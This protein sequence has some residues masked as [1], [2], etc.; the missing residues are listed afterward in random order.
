MGTKPRE[1]EDALTA[2]P[3]ASEISA[4]LSYDSWP[5]VWAD[6]RGLPVDDPTKRHGGTCRNVIGFIR[7][8]AM[9]VVLKGDPCKRIKRWLSMA[10][11]RGYRVFVFDCSAG[12][13]G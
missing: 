1:Y 13:V 2:C 8:E 3:W 4:V 6:I 5:K 7:P 9:V 12:R 11:E 10:A